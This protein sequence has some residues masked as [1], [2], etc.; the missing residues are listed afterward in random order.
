MSDGISVVIPIYN[1]RAAVARLGERIQN[2]LEGMVRP[3]EVILVNDGS[4]DGSEQMLPDLASESVHVVNHPTNRGYGAALKTGIHS[5]KYEWVA[6][7]DGDDS[8]PMDRI[9]DL[10]K[11]AEESKL[12]MVVGARTG[13]D[14]HIPWL[15][16]YVK[17]RLLN[18]ANV[19]G[20]FA[21]PDLNSGLRIMRTASLSRFLHMLPDKFSFT[22]T[23]TLA[24][25]SSGFQVGFVPINYYKRSGR[26][27]IRPIYDTL[28]FL[29]A[30][31]R[32]IMWFRPFRIFVPFGLFLILLAF[33]TVGIAWYLY[34]DIPHTTFAVLLVTGLQVLALGMLADVITKNSGM[35]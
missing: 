17:R 13:A 22:T 11:F 10:L 15:P 25:L 28:N 1:E 24:M 7:I 2:L 14:V 30:I 27:K 34:N 23:I 8:Y 4:T 33:V 3:S 16:G 20:G 29:Q 12:D 19:L 5:A 31:V 35:R 21:I 18:V 32:A 9:P 26:S 6:I